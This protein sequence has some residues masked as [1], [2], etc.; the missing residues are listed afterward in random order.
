[1]NASY[2]NKS[3]CQF[4]GTLRVKFAR[5]LDELRE[6]GSVLVAL[7]GG[8]D[9]SVL[10]AAAKI[11]LGENTLAVTANSPSLPSKELQTAEYIAKEIGIRHMVIETDELN[12]A[13][14]AMNPP[15][16]CY[17]CKKELI[18]K[19]RRIAEKEN[20][21][22]IADG[23]NADDLNQHRPGR[24]ALNEHGI[25]T[26]LADVGLTKI[27]VREI[28]RIL[29]PQVADKPSTACLSSR[30]PYGRK[31]TE[32]SLLRIGK[33]EEIIHKLSGIR[34]IR[35]R[36]HGNIARIEIG[37][38]ELDKMFNLSLISKTAKRL[39]RLGYRYVTLDMEGY[40]SGSFDEEVG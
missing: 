9:S 38:D 8:V 17:Y 28:A 20:I 36:D 11:A 39:K 40:R 19:L 18:S 6:M 12:D 16:R 1:M 3:S 14:Y 10:A 13:E 24:R 21:A 23:L 34:Q 26:P 35:V 31:I 2:R 15:T 25:S 30:I 29:V 4:E 5:L 37:I 32:Q 22:I 7:S 27:E 33:A